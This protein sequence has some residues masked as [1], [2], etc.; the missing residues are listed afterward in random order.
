MY[1]KQITINNFKNIEHTDLLFS[2][3]LNCFVGN[4]GA[5]KT[6][7]LD[8][9]HYL[10]LTK[11]FFNN[12]D[13]QNIRHSENYFIINGNFVRNDRDEKIYC[14]VQNSEKI[15]KRNDKQ[16]TRFADHLGL[17]PIVMISPTD[18]ALINDSG[19]ERRRYLNS[20]MSQLDRIYLENLIKY[21]RILMQR[22][23]L[24]KQMHEK[25]DIITVLN[26]QMNEYA[27][28][29]YEK[30]KQFIEDI[31]PY[32]THVYAN[33]SNENEQVSLTYKSDL[34]DENFITLLERSFEKDCIMQHTTTGIH[35]DDIIMKM[36]DYHIKKIGSQ[37]QQKTFLIALK[38]TQFNFFKQQTGIAPILLLDDIFDKLDLHRVQHL[39]SLVAGTDFG[40]IFLTDSNKTRLDKILE[41]QKNPFSLFNVDNGKITKT[42]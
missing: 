21:N 23:K 10:S 41:Q 28:I 37:G 25:N 34:N 4:N 30:R 16:Y 29:I 14:G 2:Q 24:L 42:E 38:L 39:I 17:I 26:E 9:M 22:N 13:R 31:Q 8:A 40:Q 7:L 18:I 11:S 12:T 33:V 6:N 35:R 19:D 3:N 15:F 1:L 20:V 36:N 5:G 32:F 27:Q